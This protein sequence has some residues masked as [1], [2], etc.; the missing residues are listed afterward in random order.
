MRRQIDF[1]GLLNSV[2]NLQSAFDEAANHLAE[3]ADDSTAKIESDWRYYE[4]LL[5]KE[6][7]LTGISAEGREAEMN[8]SYESV[9]DMVEMLQFALRNNNDDLLRNGSLTQDR[10]TQRK[11]MSE[12]DGKLPETM[13]SERRNEIIAELDKWKE[14]RNFLG[15]TIGVDDERNGIQTQINQA[16]KYLDKVFE[17]FV[18]QSFTIKPLEKLKN[19]EVTLGSVADKRSSYTNAQQRARQIQ[20]DFKIG[21]IGKDEAKREL[22]ELNDALGTL[23][24]KP[25]KIDLDTHGFEKAMAGMKKSW[26]SIKGIGS[27]IEGI[28]EA[29][30][31]DR[32]AWSTITGVVD[33]AIQIYE[34]ISGII[35]IIQTLTAVTGASNTVTAASGVATTTAAAAKT[36]AAPE[37]VAASM[38]V[39]AAVKTEAMA[40]R[41]LAASEFMAAHAY[42]P[43]AGAGIAAGFIGMMQGLVASV[44]VTP[45]ANGGIVYGPTLALMGEYSGAKSNPEVIAPLN[46]LKSLIGETGGGGGGTYEFRVKGKDLVAVLANETRINRK[47]TNIKI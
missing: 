8:T 46:K 13:S 34:G 26:N 1:D 17:G 12:N 11:Y 10:S 5:G 6:G 3:K 31:R 38:A 42:I 18:S 36:A 27:G 37:E 41:E 2:E 33:A 24:L 47:S 44:A 32:D 16:R 7:F 20:N 4:R 23:N 14:R 19:Q 25:I 22:S 30:E 9:R 35:S 43:F 29:I 15:A 39:M 21:I 40:Y 28:T 45:F